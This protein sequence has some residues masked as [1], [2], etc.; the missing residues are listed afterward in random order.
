MRTNGPIQLYPLLRIAAALAVGIFVGYEWASGV[1]QVIW[2][3]SFVASVV[4]TV[5]CW[6]WQ[7]AQS[8]MLI[9]SS[10]LLGTFITV[11]HIDGMITQFPDAEIP[12]RA[13]LLSE[14]Q[15]RGK[16]MR[17]DIQ[18][19]G[20]EYDGV[21]VKASFLRDT[22]SNNCS[23]L[24]VG[25][26]IE[27]AMRLSPPE[28]FSQNRFNYPLYLL[29]RGYTA[30]SLIIPDAWRLVSVDLRE[31]SHLARTRLTALQFRQRL[32]ER[33]LSMGV[34]DDEAAV[35][36]AMT[37][38]DRSRLTNDL[39]DLYSISGASHILALSGMHLGI[40]YL[41]LSL[42]LGLSRWN[43]LREVFIISG[44][45][46]YVFLTGFSPSAVRAAVMITVYSL[47]S[48]VNRNRMSLN[49]LALTAIIMLVYNP[50]LLYDVGFQMSFMAVFAILVI[51]P[52]AFGL[53]SSDWLSRHRVVKWVWAMT[54]LSCC[55]QIGVAP[56]TAYYF[57]RF[58]VYFLLTN[59]IVIPLATVLL[60]VS[61]AMMLSAAFPP[62]A[63][64][65]G[66]GISWLASLQNSAVAWISNL[67]CSH[68]DNISLNRLQVLF[69]YVFITAMLVFAARLIKIKS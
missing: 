62:V 56:L 1:G 43:L 3:A 35:A 4:V 2:L 14:P 55:A 48:V 19:V 15:Q 51:Y 6:R 67:P 50:L 12:C 54:V 58:S 20:G 34:G 42:V 36:V 11:R 17:T 24:H 22:I 64:L 68:I 28:N 27:A 23:R 26:G 18:I 69:I 16:V 39:R 32:M 59:F 8:F 10:Y 33:Y 52:T 37:L 46:A 57:G 9:V 65:L 5:V 41:L 29:C 61:V 63:M 45:W 53:V 30:T 40:I 7:M 66:K 47:V 25:S 38:G 21:R 13:V 31:W 49:A 60:Y 44:I